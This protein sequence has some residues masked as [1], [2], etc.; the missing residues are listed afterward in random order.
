[1]AHV[2]A[3]RLLV[4]AE[5]RMR[6]QQPAAAVRWRGGAAQWGGAKGVAQ[7]QRGYPPGAKPRR[8]C[9]CGSGALVGGGSFGGVRVCG[10][11]VRGDTTLG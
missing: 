3:A 8:G 6:L 4:R 1:M 5:A 7:G 10:G 11:G 9:V 2:Q